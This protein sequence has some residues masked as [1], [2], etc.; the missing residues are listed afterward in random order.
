MSMVG[1]VGDAHIYMLLISFIKHDSKHLLDLDLLLT[2]SI[3]I[4]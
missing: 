1:E 2:Y 4:I 3:V